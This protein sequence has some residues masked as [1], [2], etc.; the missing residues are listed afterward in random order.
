LINGVCFRSCDISDDTKQRSAMSGSKITYPHTL[1]SITH[2]HTQSRVQPR[3][4]P[5]TLNKCLCDHM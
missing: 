4:A 3:Q 5:Q 2:T 1:S